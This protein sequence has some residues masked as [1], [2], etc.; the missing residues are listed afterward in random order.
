MSPQRRTALVSVGAACLLIAI[1]LVAGLSSSSLGLLAEAAHSGTDLAAALLTFFAVSVAVRP[2]DRGHPYGHGKAQNLA[3]LGEAGFLVAVSI[4]IA[5]LAIA[6]LAGVVEFEVEPTWWTFAAIALVLAI[7]ASRAV[8]SSRT[9]R[10]YDSEALRANALHFGSDFA[11]TLAVLAGL[12]AAALG[13]PAGDSLAAL[14]V[15]VLVVLAAVRLGRRNVDVLMDRSPE[16][17]ARV[18]RQ[19]VTALEPPVELRRLRLRSAGGELFAD[20]VIDVAP[21][22]AVGQGHAAADRVEAALR[23]A[24]PGIDVVVHVEPHGAHGDVRERVLAAAVTVSHVREVH[25]LV[26]LEVGDGLEVSLHLKLPGDLS[27]DRAHDIAEQVE[28][29]I[30]GEV[31]EVT[32]VQTHLE[33]LKEAVSGEEIAVDA[34]AVEAAVREETGADPRELRFVRTDDGV[35]AFLT[36]ALGGDESL[37]Q[38]HARANAVEE[39]VRSAVPAIADVVIHTEP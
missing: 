24:L 1:K 8:V 14:F 17:A 7:D 23:E 5:G 29:A 26:L 16:E 35:V 21:G 25:N 9:A 33:P 39:R 10:A 31:A 30:L 3:A 20:V 38:A 18:A 11:G 2:A 15:S 19:A 12:V 28:H 32:S 34:A 27:L 37:A 4:L 6:R 36:L 22:A 13:F